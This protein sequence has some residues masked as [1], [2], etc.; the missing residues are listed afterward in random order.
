M[1]DAKLEDGSTIALVF[2]LT[3]PGI[4]LLWLF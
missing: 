4:I 2:R 1:L 3:W